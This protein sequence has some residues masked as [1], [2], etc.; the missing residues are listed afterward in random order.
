MIHLINSIECWPVEF[1][2]VD[3]KCANGV[4]G[5]FGVAGFNEVI[6]VYGFNWGRGV[7]YYAIHILLYYRMIFRAIYL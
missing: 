5:Y 4:L 6:F 3:I 1:I 7:V 2:G